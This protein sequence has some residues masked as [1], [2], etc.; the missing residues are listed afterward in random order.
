MTHD[1]TRISLPIILNEPL[2][3]L[4]KMC[5]MQINHQILENTANSMPESGEDSI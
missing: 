1:L 4:Q 5:E 3:T 2:N